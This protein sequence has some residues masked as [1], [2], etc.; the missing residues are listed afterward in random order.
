MRFRS[1]PSTRRNSKVWTAAPACMTASARPISLGAFSALGASASA[2]PSSRGL[3]ARSSTR[4]S[5]PAR[6]RA[7]AAARPPI[8]APTTRALRLPFNEIEVASGVVDHERVGIAAG[9]L[10]VDGSALGEAE[11]HAAADLFG[12]SGGERNAVARLDLAVGAEPAGVA[13]VR[14]VRR[15]AEVG[16][17]LV[18]SLDHLADALERGISVLLDQRPVRRRDPFQVRRVN[19]QLAAVGDDATELVARFSPDPELV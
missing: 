1:A 3:S 13:H 5:Q 15:D 14:Q 2:K 18:G 11:L 10:D 17:Q 7:M 4:T 8:P 6:R 9:G 12:D 16:A 19:H